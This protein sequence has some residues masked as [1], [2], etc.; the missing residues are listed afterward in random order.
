MIATGD[1]SMTDNLL[2]DVM[3]GRGGHVGLHMLPNEF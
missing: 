1:I 3:M 2:I